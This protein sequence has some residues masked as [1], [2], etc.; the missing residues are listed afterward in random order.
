MVENCGEIGGWE[1][2]V[3]HKVAIV[4]DWLVTYAGA[5]RVLEQ[6]LEIYPEAD[7]FCLV[8]FLPEKQR[9]FLHG[10]NVY[11]TFL[12]HLPF[13]RHHYRAYLPLMPLAVEQ[14]NV[15]GYD[16]VISS[17]HC[18]AKGVITGPDQLHISYVHTPVRYAWDMTFSYLQDAGLDHGLKGWIAK[19]LLHYLRI[20]DCRTAFGVD[21]YIAN[22]RFIARRIKKIYGR[23][24]VVIHPPVDVDKFPLCMEKSDYYLTASRL[25][26]YK[27]VDLSVEAFRLMPEKKLVIIGDGPQHQEIMR[28]A[29]Q[30]IR[31]LG[32]QSDAVLRTYMQQARAFV[33]AAEEDFGITPVESMACGTPVIAYGKGGV[34]DSVVEGV[35]GC[36][37]PHQTV[38][39]ICDA[40]RRF[41]AT[42]LKPEDCRRQAEKFAV[43]EFHRAFQAF[44]SGK[45]DDDEDCD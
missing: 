23:D 20:W 32:Y 40:V 4:C 30:N 2:R 37:F 41:E 26:S 5:E 39:S 9:A 22:S 24:A 15:H 25:V 10:K 13:V 18:V 35:T 44:L 38:E 6:F 17:S 7:V 27:K 28:R 36:F 29:T 12:Q 34:R 45:R 8:D 19:L 14:I 42:D 16:I 1:K 31:M 33:F 3:E 43:S 21:A 11:T